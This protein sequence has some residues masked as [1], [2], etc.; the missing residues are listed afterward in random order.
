[1]G[2]YEGLTSSGSVFHAFFAMAQPIATAGR[3]DVFSNTAQ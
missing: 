2:D 3:T 1:V